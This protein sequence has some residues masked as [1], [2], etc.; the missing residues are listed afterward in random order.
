MCSLQEVLA[1]K[2]WI[3]SSPAAFTLVNC[4]V[5][6]PT[7]SSLSPEL[8]SLT[9]DDGIFKRI[10]PTRSFRP[11]DGIDLAGL[12]ICPGLIDGH[13]H[14][15]APPGAAV[16]FHE[17]TADQQTMHE[18][19]F[20][21]SQITT[22]RATDPLRRMLRRGFTTVRDCG[23]ATKF[24]AD[25]V[26]EGLILGPRLFQCGKALSQT[27]GHGDHATG[28]SGGNSEGACC[29]GHSETIARTIDGVPAVTKATREELKQGADFIKI[30]IGG[31]V[32]S[33]QCGLDSVQFLPEEV[34]AITRTASQMGGKMVSREQRSP[35]D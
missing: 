31:G 29:G 13:V 22:L 33:D 34:Q 8:M 27:G 15:C 25:A 4:R 14:V 11:A 3:Q 1:T 9:V 6:D 23:G 26:S 28:V 32:A 24:V 18:L 5:V 19:V 21:P 30:F 17:S 2:P 20:L 10:Q 35:I 12:I 7:T 16:S